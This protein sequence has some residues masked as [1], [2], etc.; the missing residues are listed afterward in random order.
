MNGESYEAA[1]PAMGVFVGTALPAMGASSGTNLQ[2]MGELYG[3][4]P[5]MNGEPNEAAP[6]AMGA[7]YRGAAPPA[8]GASN[9]MN[10]QATGDPQG[11]A[12]PMIILAE[13][14]VSWKGK[15]CGKANESLVSSDVVSLPQS[16]ICMDTFL[17]PPFRLSAFS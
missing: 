11:T 17:I 7:S 2:A 8:M 14:Q 3:T 9:G 4:A 16:K 5:P 10:L 15:D 6:P 1:P 12:P 13:Q